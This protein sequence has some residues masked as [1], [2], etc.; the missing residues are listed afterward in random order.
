MRY[1]VKIMEVFSTLVEVE[2]DN[3]EEAQAKAEDLYCENQSTIQADTF[4][5]TLDRDQWPLWEIK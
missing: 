1:A 4:E 3:V 5:Y 2:A